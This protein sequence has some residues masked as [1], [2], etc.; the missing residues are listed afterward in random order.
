M[1]SPPLLGSTRP[2]KKAKFEHDRD[3]T[4][5]GSG[6]RGYG[7]KADENVD[8]EEKEPEFVGDPA[9]LEVRT[10]SLKKP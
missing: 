5:S 9:N 2:S 1:N 3:V 8:E 6:S 7:V 10:S 4:P